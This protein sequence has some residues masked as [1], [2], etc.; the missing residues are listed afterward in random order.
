MDFFK[1]LHRS[2]VEQ[3]IDEK[4]EQISDEK[5]LKLKI[6]QLTTLE[7]QKVEV[8][9]KEFRF[10]GRDKCI[11]SNVGSSDGAKEVKDCILSANKSIT[12]VSLYISDMPVDWD[13]NKSFSW[14]DVL[15]ACKMNGV[16]NVKVIV[17]PPRSNWERYALERLHRRGIEVYI[18]EE[19]EGIEGIAHH[20]IVMIDE[21]MQDSIA[22]LQSANL[23][24][25]VIKNADFYIF[26]AKKQNEIGHAILSNWLQDLIIRCKNGAGRISQVD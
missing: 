8:I 5:D 14:C 10:S 13:D 18:F 6:S 11:L 17:R 2:Q 23:S 7:R 24:P 1:T 19:F 20:K 3:K 26:I 15:I 12:I 21:D 16:E 22:V 25:E 4:G 9:P